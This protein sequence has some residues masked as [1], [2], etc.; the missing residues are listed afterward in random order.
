MTTETGSFNLP[1]S[2]AKS[3][4][5]EPN[6]L[7]HLIIESKKVAT[8][9]H[10]VEYFGGT[11]IENGAPYDIRINER[12]FAEYLAKEFGF[13]PEDLE[14][15]KIYVI[16]EHPAGMPHKF[17]DDPKEN[18]RLRNF[19]FDPDPKVYDPKR[20]FAVFK[21]DEEKD[22]GTQHLI[23]YAFN[24]WKYLN[25]EKEAILRFARIKRKR[26]ES[27]NTL[28]K[29]TE[30]FEKQ[31]DVPRL[32]RRLSNY[33]GHVGFKRRKSDDKHPLVPVERAEKFLDRF[34]M[35]HRAKN[36]IKD[37]VVH[38]ETSHSFQYKVSWKKILRRIGLKKA[39]EVLEIMAESEEIRLAKKPEWSGLV[40][41]RMKDFHSSPKENTS[42]AA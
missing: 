17:S 4:M 35:N 11:T 26:E 13:K 33:L 30:L 19:F 5:A 24:F 3:F 21:E 25:R 10:P 40:E 38:H 8:L 32:G 1:E 23:F 36:A 18:K 15:L 14:K 9:Y 7:E 41:F 6:Q 28:D 29:R 12:L 22:G 34:L 39:Q 16:G 37:H 20:S 42:E 2:L 27:W 31:R